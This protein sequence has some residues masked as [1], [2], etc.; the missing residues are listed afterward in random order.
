MCNHGK[1]NPSVWFQRLIWVP[2]QPLQRYEENEWRFCTCTK[3]ANGACV[4]VCAWCVGFR[5]CFTFVPGL[6]V[7]VNRCGLAGKKGKLFP[8]ERDGCVS[9]S[10]ISPR[11]PH[12]HAVNHLLSL[13]AKQQRLLLPTR[14]IT[15]P[16]AV[17]RYGGGRRLDVRARY[18]RKANVCVNGVDTQLN[19]SWLCCCT[20]S[21]SRLLRLILKQ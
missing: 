21:A 19:G 10:S 6:V 9:G 15:S 5:L 18:V 16:A 7:N 12:R 13:T 17:R 8:D 3:D 20:S 4:C 14:P 2:G 1:E 11:L